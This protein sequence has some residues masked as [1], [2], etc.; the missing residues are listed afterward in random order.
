MNSLAT[1]GNNTGVFSKF[2]TSLNAL[3][4]AEIL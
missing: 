4:A 3:S 2:E 1:E